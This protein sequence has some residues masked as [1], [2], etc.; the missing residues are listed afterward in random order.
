MEFMSASELVGI[1]A[2]TVAIIGPAMVMIL[3]EGVT[4]ARPVPVRVRRRS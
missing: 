3:A 4:R 1:I 2:F